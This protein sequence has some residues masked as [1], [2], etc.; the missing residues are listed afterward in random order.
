MN[1]GDSWISVRKYGHEKRLVLPL[2]Q[3]DTPE[4]LIAA[5][6]QL[7][8]PCQVSYAV[9]TQTS[10]SVNTLK[11]VDFSYHAITQKVTLTIQTQIQLELSPTPKLMLGMKESHL[12]S[13]TH[14][15]M[16]VVDV[17]HEFILS[18]STV[19]S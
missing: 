18:M 11:D 17:N 12:S 13:G 10:V 6:N 8:T 1:K 14:E 2:G 5:L 4:Q 7:F 9:E 16:H 3:Y 19:I 15:G